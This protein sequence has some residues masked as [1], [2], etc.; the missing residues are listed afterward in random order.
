MVSTAAFARTAGLIGDPARA[1]MLGAL[2]DGRALTAR[3][4]ADVAG[5]TPQTA[6]GHLTQL[7]EAGLLA[8]ERQGRHRY[9]RLAS[10]AVAQMI[11]GIMAFAAAGEGASARPAVRTGPRD[12]RMRLARTCYD[13]LAGRMAVA[14]ADAMVAR[15]HLELDADG[16]VLTETGDALW[17]ALGADLDAARQRRGRS[18]CRPCLDWS[19]RRPHIAG[20][21]GAALCRCCFAQ[22][23]VRRMESSSRALTITPPGL[24]ALKRHFGVDLSA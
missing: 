7:S 22:G 17:R 3:E 9:H 18:F 12:G 14:L 19:E 4:L 13:H 2:M 6:S 11:E 10:S 23:W 21:V 24:T 5:V 8:V 16:G 1:N 20:S 15:G